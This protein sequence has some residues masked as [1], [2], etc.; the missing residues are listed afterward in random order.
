MLQAF[1]ASS[2]RLDTAADH[3]L[4]AQSAAM[5]EPTGNCS[6]SDR[7]DGDDGDLLAWIGRLFVGTDA[8]LD[9]WTNHGALLDGGGGGGRPVPG[10]TE[11]DWTLLN[12]SL[13]ARLISLNR[14]R[15]LPAVYI[16]LAKRLESLVV[17]QP[18]AA[19]SAA[20]VGGNIFLTFLVLLVLAS[21]IPALIQRNH[22]YVLEF[23]VFTIRVHL[24]VL[25][26]AVDLCKVPLTGVYL[27]LV[28]LY[29]AGGSR[30][31]SF[32]GSA[33]RL[34]AAG[35][36]GAGSAR[37]AAVGSLGLTGRLSRPACAFL[38]RTLGYTVLYLGRLQ[39]LL[40]SLERCIFRL[41]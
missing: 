9:P 33:T 30:G 38:I 15:L 16:Q 17:D 34:P 27:L 14:S 35:G 36:S 37:A 5:A 19:A 2:S 12:H 20:A 26:Y 28:C 25:Y 1:N 13:L 32:G 29:P 18:A 22:R 7:R 11:L 23:F 41:I 8:I 21:L 4:G 24:N 40:A 3:R 39:T 6:A 10:A 31:G